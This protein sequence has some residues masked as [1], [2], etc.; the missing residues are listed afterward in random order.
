MDR[1]VL[2]KKHNLTEKGVVKNYK[3]R[4]NKWKRNNSQM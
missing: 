3:R 1:G 2:L 4:K